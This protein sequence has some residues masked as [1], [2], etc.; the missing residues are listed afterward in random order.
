MIW[1]NLIPQKR[2]SSNYSPKQLGVGHIYCCVNLPV[3]TKDKGFCRDIIGVALDL[4]NSKL[5]FSK[6]GTWQNSGVPTS[7][8]TGTG[9]LSITAAG[10][11]PLGAYFAASGYWHSG[12]LTSNFNFG[13]GYFGTTAISSG[14]ADDAGYGDFEYDVPAGYY[15]LCT[16]N[17][18]DQS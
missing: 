4:T 17:L 6:N 15:T 12:T 5:Y 14:N 18:G 8:A 13:N 3:K 10:S 7:G 11:T 1:R 2:D 9:A 16:N